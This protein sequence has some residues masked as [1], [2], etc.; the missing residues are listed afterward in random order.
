MMDDMGTMD[1]MDILQ[2]YAN[3]V[4]HLSTLAPH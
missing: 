2:L 1:E 4:F 3:A